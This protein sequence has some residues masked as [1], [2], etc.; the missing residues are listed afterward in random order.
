MRIPSTIRTSFDPRSIGRRPMIPVSLTAAELHA[1]IRWCERE[2]TA[3]LD[4]NH[5]AAADLLFTRAAALRE[6]GR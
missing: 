1:V 4:D 2:A 3:A 5:D 6:A